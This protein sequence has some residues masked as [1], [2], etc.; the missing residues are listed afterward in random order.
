MI[1]KSVK[2]II[3]LITLKVILSL[4][5]VSLD[6]ELTDVVYVH[7]LS[8]SNDSFETNQNFK[9]NLFLSIFNEENFNLIN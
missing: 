1:F 5:F 8:M 4:S 9:S 2:F 7:T 3:S 6:L